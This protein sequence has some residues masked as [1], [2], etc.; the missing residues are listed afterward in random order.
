MTDL[1]IAKQKI[2]DEYI[3]IWRAWYKDIPDVC[4]AT[5]QIYDF[6]KT[7]GYC[8]KSDKI[9]LFF[10]KEDLLKVLI[11]ETEDE[12]IAPPGYPANWD[13]CRI[14]LIHEMLHEYQYKILGN[15]FSIEG[16]ELAKKYDRFFRDHQ[17]D[18]IFATAIERNAKYL[19]MNPDEL[20][21]VLSGGTI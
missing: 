20:I 9:C 8:K 3:E 4:P 19:N 7:S 13:I 15:E 18:H 21:N 10:D 16:A 1:E 6:T 5:L 11:R 2:Q 14:E 17:H 12:F